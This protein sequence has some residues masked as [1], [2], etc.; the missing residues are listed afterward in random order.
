MNLF[1]Y[2]EWDVEYEFL[3]SKWGVDV[4]QYTWDEYYEKF[5]DWATS[6]QIKH[7]S[8]LTSYGAPD[9]ITEVAMELCDEKAASRLVNRALDA[10]VRFG[11]AHV[12][13]LNMSINEETIRR[14]VAGM[15]GAFTDDHLQDLAGC[16]DDDVFLTMIK[17]SGSSKHSTDAI[18]EILETS[19]DDFVREMALKANDCFS[20]EQLGILR[21]SFDEDTMEILI[22][23][24]LSK[25]VK[26]PPEEVIEWCYTGI[27]DHLI[28]KMA[29]TVDGKFDDSQAEELY[30]RLPEEEYRRITKKH[31]L[32]MHE[33]PVY[34]DF[35]Q[36]AP[37]APKLGFFGTLFAVIAGVGAASNHGNRHNGRCNGDCANCPPHYG[38][39]YGRWYY[40]HDHVHGCEFGGNRGSG[41]MD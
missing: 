33:E 37:P 3:V 41:S 32:D 27:A 39:R 19:N 29:L 34:D 20:A 35:I 7:L 4:R 40:G 28:E 24:A 13:D 2:V 8:D 18:M 21:D 31:K 36:E 38:Y 9:E 16:F 30:D 6:T 26:F 25:G 23:R 15:E 10:G 12:E 14:V 11:P 22:E 1:V 5:Y 17:K